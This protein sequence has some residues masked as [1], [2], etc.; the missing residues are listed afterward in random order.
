MDCSDNAGHK[1]E[2]QDG[3]VLKLMNDL[4][5]MRIDPEDEFLKVMNDFKALRIDTGGAEVIPEVEKQFNDIKMTLNMVFKNF[6]DF[7]LILNSLLLDEPQVKIQEQYQEIVDKIDIFVSK[8]QLVL[9]KFEKKY[10][11]YMLNKL[12]HIS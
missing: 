9:E 11:M 2:I 10:H 1:G 6:Q 12:L 3:E 8:Y 4:K 7:K 5:A